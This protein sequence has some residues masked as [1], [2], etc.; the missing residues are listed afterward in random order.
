MLN[1]YDVLNYC[2]ELGFS[3]TTQTLRNYIKTGLC[4]GA[5]NTTN[6]IEARGILPIYPDRT[7]PE[8]LAAKVML[9]VSG[10]KLDRIV[11]ILAKNLA[12]YILTHGVDIIFKDNIDIF[13]AMTN[14]LDKSHGELEFFDNIIKYRKIAKPSMKNILTGKGEQKA[15]CKEFWLKNIVSL[16]AEWLTL[17]L[18]FNDD[19][20]KVLRRKSTEL[21]ILLILR[22]IKIANPI[23]F[24]VGYSYNGYM[25]SQENINFLDIASKLNSYVNYLRNN[26]SV[27]SQKEKDFN[28]LSL[29]YQEANRLPNFIEIV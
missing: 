27:D 1:Q 14:G 11:V 3:L 28:K 15:K 19:D 17:Y 16:A 22:P 10:R 21:D 20:F 18:N 25:F 8:V 13:M 9:E 7:L 2:K 24:Y 12:S 23:I 29:L 26:T 6:G 4:T 5:V